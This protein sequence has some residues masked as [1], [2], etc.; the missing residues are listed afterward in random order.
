MRPLP[1]FRVLLLAAAVLLVSPLPTPALK[2]QTPTQPAPPA[3]YSLLHDRERVVSLDG[4]WRFHP[5]DDPHWADPQLNDTDWRLLRS[6]QPWT[7]QGLHTAGPAW[8]RCTVQDV[9]PGTELTLLLPAIDAGYDLFADGKRIGSV[10]PTKPGEILRQTLPASFLVPPKTAADPPTLVLALR[11]WVTP[12]SLQFGAGPEQGGAA[13]GDPGLIQDRM[14]AL[15][16]RRTGPFFGTLLA[17]CLDI[18]V[19]CAM[20]TFVYLRRSE[21]LYLRFAVALFC[22]ATLSILTTCFRLTRAPILP[23]AAA[24]ECMVTL[25]LL[26]S[27]V[28]FSQ[29]FRATRGL[30]WKLSFG[31]CFLPMITS[32]LWFLAKLPLVFGSI[33]EALALG[34]VS[35]WLLFV[36]VSRALQGDPDAR[37]LIVPTT[38]L[39]GVHIVEPLLGLTWSLGLQHIRPT[40]EDVALPLGPFPINLFALGEILLSS[41]LLVFLIRRFVLSR[42]H[43]ERFE[44]ELEAAREVQHV[45]VPETLPSTPGLSIHSAYAPA[46]E[47]GGDF[48][49]ILPL[50]SGATLV[51]IGDVAGK[52]MPAALTVSLVIGTLRTLADYTESPAQILTGL[53]R[54]LHD[55]GTGFTTCLALHF[56]PDRCALTLANAGHL[57][58]Y[59]N[60][61]ELP[62]EPSLPLGLDPAATFAEN[63]LALHET[64]HL[65]LLT[66][67]VPEAMHHHQLFGFDRTAALA[68]QPA[69]HIAEAARLY[70]QT[71]DIT[72]LTIDILSLVSTAPLPQLLGG[73]Q[74]A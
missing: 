39:F 51:V 55:R 12:T 4:L 63:T 61:H 3:T 7:E 5:G 68:R 60:G 45:L 73:L 34:G 32:F 58:P 59:R 36:L 24:I 14:Q 40:I 17:I 70:G 11:V 10:T 28:F 64:D 42:S 69:A 57:P 50:P 30:L 71:D 37:L 18:L 27:L 67:G 43:E 47:V 15:Q 52:G 29:L 6:D 35:V 8:Y 49:Q 20:L 54:R 22:Q 72:V 31:L 21:R 41:S 62:T 1:A 53:N 38:F 48:F 9:P 16:D 44:V 19:G 25:T 66:D 74:P 56:A 2:A 46:Q 65:T 23:L 13:L 26:V 33:A